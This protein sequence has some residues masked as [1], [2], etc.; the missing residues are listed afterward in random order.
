MIKAA[1]YA[2]Y[3][4]DN[5]REESIEAQLRAI[6]EY[7]K[8]EGYTIVKIYVDEARSATTDDRPNFL[9]MIEDSSKGM[10]DAVIVHKL[11]RFSRNRYDSAFYKRLLKKNGVKLISVLEPL[12]DSPES[13]ILESVLEGMAEYY[14]RNLAREVMKG[15]KETALQAK[16]TGGLPPLGYDVD[17]EGY[18]VINEQEAIIVKKIFSLYLDGYSYQAIA[19]ILNRQG[20]RTKLG[21]PFGKNSIYDILINEKYKGTYVFNKRSSKDSLGKRNNRRFKD[22]E[23]IIRIPNGMPAIIDEQTFDKVQEKIQARKRGPRMSEKR[24][25]LLTGKIFCGE[26]GSHYAG[27]SYRGGRNG[28]KYAIYTCTRRVRTK[29][30]KNKSIRQDVIEKYVMDQLLNKIFEENMIHEIT[31]K[32]LEYVRQF[33][34]E[35]SGEIKYLERKIKDLEAKIERLIDAIAEGYGDKEMIDKRMKAYK[36]EKIQCESRLSELKLKEYS[37]IN[38]EKVADYLRICREAL[39]SGDPKAQRKIIETFVDKIIIYPDRIDLSLKVDMKF[40]TERDKAG[41]GEP[42]LTI[43]LSIALNHIYYMYKK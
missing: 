38:E 25:Y 17:E 10:F 27:N 11:D 32:V 29:T 23:N 24:F 35:K 19:D 9:Q 43:P 4:S 40:V 22:N 12:D 36:A 14:S 21:N 15:M 5:Q 39:L 7:A 1:A 16:H 37:W 13:I 30:C 26:C 42:C 31:R 34:A 6:K 3:S 18:Y 41:G 20:Y 33:E 8:K 28:K 2:R